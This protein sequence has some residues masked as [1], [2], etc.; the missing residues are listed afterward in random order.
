MINLLNDTA[1]RGFFI[2]QPTHSLCTLLYMQRYI[3]NS[4]SSKRIRSLVSTPRYAIA[5]SIRVHFHILSTQSFTIQG[6]CPGQS[7]KYHSYHRDTIQDQFCGCRTSAPVRKAVQVLHY[8]W[9]ETAWP[10]EHYGNVTY[11]TAWVCSLLNLKRMHRARVRLEN[12]WW[13]LWGGL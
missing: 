12:A 3:T 4:S 13:V 2:V 6:K 1:L 11:P 7:Y 8:K 5:K 10:E 9:R